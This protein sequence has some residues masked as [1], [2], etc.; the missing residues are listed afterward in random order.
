M[1]CGWLSGVEPQSYFST[2]EGGSG[3]ESAVAYTLQ[4]AFKTCLT[5]KRGCSEE[6]LIQLASVT[7]N[8]LTVSVSELLQDNFSSTENRLH[9]V[10]YSLSMLNRV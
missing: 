3:D 6:V 1:A 10:S 4:L 9:R 8:S 5:H 7:S 2:I